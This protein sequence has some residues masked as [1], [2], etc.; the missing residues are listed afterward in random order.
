MDARWAGTLAEAGAGRE[1]RGGR[2]ACCEGGRWWMGGWADGCAWS[3]PGRSSVVPDVKGGG[4]RA[5]VRAC[6]HCSATRHARRCRCAA[7]VGRRRFEVCRLVGVAHS[8]REAACLW[9]GDWRRRARLLLLPPCSHTAAACWL[10]WTSRF[11]RVTAPTL[12]AITHSA[13]LIQ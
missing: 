12:L 3:W 2:R 4:V 1:M 7:A 10:G 13:R 6:V 5:C 9:C 11:G 8:P